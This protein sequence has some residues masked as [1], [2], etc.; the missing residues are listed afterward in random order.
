MMGMKEEMMSDAVDEVMD[1]DGE[2]IEETEM[3]IQKVMDEV[4]L[5]FQNKVGVSNAALQAKQQ[6]E[7]NE[8]EDKELEARLAALKNGLK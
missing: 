7:A 3:E 2:E 5:D 6:Q 8:T 4:G 1:E